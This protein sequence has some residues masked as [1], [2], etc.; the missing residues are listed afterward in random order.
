MSSFNSKV[1]ELGS[2]SSI[3]AAPFVTE[4]VLDNMQQKETQKEKK[5]EKVKNPVSSF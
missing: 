4:Q 5:A 2:K 1:A 3:V